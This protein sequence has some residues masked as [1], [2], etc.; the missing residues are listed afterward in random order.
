ME[1]KTTGQRIRALRRSKKLTQAQLAKIA[2]VSSPAVTEWE[3][4]SYLPKAASL[5]AMAKEFNVSTDYI[6]KGIEGENPATEAQQ[7]TT[8]HEA[9]NVSFNGKP[10]RKIPVLDFVQAGLWRG[11]VYDGI[12]PIGHTYTDYE[13]INPQDV[14]GVTV[15]G[16]SMSPRFMPNDELVIDP[17]LAPQPGNFVIAQ[18]GDY[19]VTFKKYRVTGYDEEGREQ[20][21]LVPLNPDFGTLDSIQHKISIIGVVVKHIQNLR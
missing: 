5:D 1:N 15:D 4:D 21:Q 16:M 8:S 6:L 9:S 11:V 20:F 12:H 2:G 14:F 18:N 19:E 10:L 7:E 3:K 13:G 17:N